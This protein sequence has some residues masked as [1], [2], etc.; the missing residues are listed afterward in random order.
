VINNTLNM[1]VIGGHEGNRL[2]AYY[3][4]EHCLTIG[5]GFNL[6]ASSAPRI[7]A[8]AQVVYSAIRM[9]HALTPAQS[10]AIFLQQYSLVA[11]QAR[12]TFVDIATW[13]DNAVAVACDMIFELGLMGFLGFHNTVKAFRAKDWAGVVAG[14]RESKLASEVPGRVQNNIEMLKQILAAA[15]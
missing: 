3:D 10:D 5:R 8:Q 11:A 9:G 1:S 13:P 12:A 2:V 14:I 4:T 15:T 7:C 6:D